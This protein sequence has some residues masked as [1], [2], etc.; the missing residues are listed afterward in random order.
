MNNARK[1]QLLEKWGTPVR[2]LDAGHVRLVD[3]MGD[4]LAVCQAARVSYGQ[5]TKTPE[6]DRNL[7]RYMMRHGH[8][9]PFESCTIKLHLKL[10]MDAHRQHI[11]HR[12]F[13][14][15][16]YST[17]YSEAIDDAMRTLPKYWRSQ[18]SSSKQG[19]SGY[20]PETWEELGEEPPAVA[21][22]AGYSPGEYLCLR[23]QQAQELARKVYEERLKYGV[24]KEQARK[25]LP[26]ST[27]TELYWYGNLR[28]LLHYLELRLHPHAQQEIR[29]YAEIMAMIVA[30]W[31]P[32]TWEAFRDYQLNAVTFSA[33]EIELIKH[34]VSE[35]YDLSAEALAEE[36][37]LLPSLA[38]D[39]EL[40]SKRERAA[41]WRKIGVIP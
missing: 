11:R 6:E 38:D 24:A 22:E 39:F 36:T 29:A 41:F 34:L 2:V 9:T 10:P 40:G 4:D 8:G 21:Q 13:G 31:V 12:T 17:R 32:W 28:N 18:S 16:E 19:S 26:L 33:Q 15:N 7:I 35:G 37:S 14:V 20:L 23:E 3:L 25:D 5:G 27:Y 1:V 30:D